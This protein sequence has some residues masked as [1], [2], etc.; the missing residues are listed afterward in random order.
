MY[1]A[2]RLR[3]PDTQSAIQLVDDGSI[4]DGLPRFVL[5]E[6][7]A[8]LVDRCGQLCLAH[9]LGQARLLQ[10]HLE[11]V[12][13]CGMLESLPI[14]IQLRRI[15]THRMRRL[16]PAGGNLLSVCTAPLR[17]AAFTTVALFAALPFGAVFVRMTGD[18]S[19]V[20]PAMAEGPL[21][22]AAGPGRLARNKRAF[23]T[24]TCSS[25]FKWLEP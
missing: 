23:E 2:F 10:R 21:G 5:V 16:V 25:E 4:R 6:H 17:R 15:R 9:L 18:Q 22:I 12:R 19:C 14:L 1:S 7:G 11:V 24:E 3:Q 13:H 20:V 8:L